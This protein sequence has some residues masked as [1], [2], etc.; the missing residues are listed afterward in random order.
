MRVFLLGSDAA[1]WSIDRDREFTA[2]ALVASGHRLVRNPLRAGAVYCVWWNALEARLWRPLRLKKVVAMVTNDLD[3]QDAT[4]AKVRGAVDVW[5]VAHSGQRR[6]LVEHGVPEEA[7]HYC[8]FY[9]D[10]AEFV[11]ATAPREQLALEAGV[12]YERVRDRFLVG[13]FQRDS[14]G[15]DLSKAKWQKDP[16]LLVEILERVGSERALLVLA[17]PR[18][19]YVLDQ[20]RRRSIPYLFVGREPP[21]GSSADDMGVNTLSTGRI[22]ALW[23]LIDMYLVPSRSEGGPK[24]VLEA[25]L[26]ET[27][28]ASTPVGMARDLMPE[29]LLYRGADEGAALVR[30]QIDGRPASEF[31]AFVSRV[32]ELNRFDAFRARVDGA[33]AAAA[34]GISA[35]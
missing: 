26:T 35:R 17:G 33:L 10:E 12:E 14:L 24:A 22:G 6:F 5:A 32:R 4:F 19:H 3:H 11:P 16:D 31:A 18:R 25:G 28:I 13:S 8:P 30:R 2:R 29:E 7:I 23:R 27:P 34:S 21:P 20:C 15:A 1:G 9:V